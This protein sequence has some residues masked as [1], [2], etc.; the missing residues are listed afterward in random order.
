MERNHARTEAFKDE[1]MSKIVKS[2]FSAEEV[3]CILN[4]IAHTVETFALDVK[5]RTFEGLRLDMYG[6]VKRD[7]ERR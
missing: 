7:G 4:D 2:D 1:I 3:I 6:K 5:V